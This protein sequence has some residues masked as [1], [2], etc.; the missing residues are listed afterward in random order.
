MKHFLLLVITMAAVMLSACSDDSFS[1]SRS[2]RL[3]FSVDT[4]TM[5]TVFSGVPSPTYSF[6]V[7]NRNSSALRIRQVRLSR[8][9]QSGFRVNV[10]GIYLDNSN[11]SQASDFEVR[12][13]DSIRVFVE[14]TSFAS[15]SDTPQ[16]VDDRLLFLLESG[17]Q[18]EVPIR[19]W[20]WDALAI[21]NLTVSRDTV[22]ST[23]K[24]IVV[25]GGITVDSG[26]VLTLRS[27]A[28][29]FFHSGAGIDV[30]GT[31]RVEGEKDNEVVMR[32]DRLDKMFSYLP[33]DRVSGQWR[34]IN[35]LASSSGN[36]FSFC[37]IHS[38]C[39]AIVVDSADYDPQCPR[40][41][42]RNSTVHNNRGN[43]L[44]A[45]N[46]YVRLVNCQ[47]TNALGDCVAMQGGRLDL[48]YCT[49]AQ[50]YP[51]DASRGLALRFIPAVNPSFRSRLESVNTV[52]TGYASDVLSCDTTGVDLVFSHCRLRTPSPSD[53]LV[54]SRI[55][56]STVFE[57]PSDSIQGD[58]HFVSID[59][60][61]QY[62]DFHPDSL[63]PLRRK[64]TPLEA[65]RDDRE[66]KQRSEQ[67]TIGCYD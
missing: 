58:A 60:S 57:S 64:A 12:K 14:L 50:F 27:P 44:R 62:Y 13:G 43:G 49:L 63:S 26:A 52:V 21:T 3:S 55:F 53:S 11:G 54:L 38:A 2:D 25:Y 1:T 15:G 29:L 61:L 34:G 67:P 23:I 9:N 37:D 7:Y 18:Q 32:G 51:F 22:I 40:L 19:A 16:P 47:L 31:L 30:G 48:V 66:G 59:L 28:R 46:A 42:L 35:I 45:T 8:G 24:P 10:D 20:T 5:D 17:E 33:Y 4:L 6:N 41:I 56:P 36:D 39:D 65:I